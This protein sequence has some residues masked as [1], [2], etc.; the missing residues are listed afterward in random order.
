MI[1]RKLLHFAVIV[2]MLVGMVGFVLPTPAAAAGLLISP[3]SVTFSPQQINTQGGLPPAQ[4]GQYVIVNN[5]YSTPITINDV[6][7]DTAFGNATSFAVSGNGCLANGV[8]YQ[9]Q[10]GDNCQFG[11]VFNPK[12]LGDLNSR[13]I[14]NSTDLN[15][16][17]LPASYVS[18][19]GTGTSPSLE[20]APTALNFTA[21]EVNTGQSPDQGVV[22]RNTGQGA[23][24]VYNPTLNGGAPSNFV[25]T[26]NTCGGTIGPSLTCEIRVAFF[27]QS[28]GTKTETLQIVTSAN[29]TT[30]Q[31]AQ[32]LLT[33]AAMQGTI[34]ANP[35]SINF[36]DRLIN[37]IS[38]TTTV[39]LTNN[40]G[41]TQTIPAMSIIND[42]GSNFFL[43]ADNCT[44]QTLA[45]NGG[46][47]TFG[48]F[49]RPTAAG[50]QAA[51]VQISRTPGNGPGVTPLLVPMNGNGLAGGGNVTIAPPTKDFGSTPLGQQGSA[52]AFVVTNNGPSTLSV[53]AV[54]INGPNAG[55]FSIIFFGCNNG[56]V[57][58]PTGGNCTVVVEYSPTTP[59]IGARVAS[60]NV[61]LSEGATPGPTVAS[62]AAALNATATA[63]LQQTATLTPNPQDFGSVQIGAQST[64]VVFTMTNTGSQPIGPLGAPVSVGAN[65]DQFVIVSASD[66]FNKTLTTASPTCTFSAFFKPTATG[67]L[68]AS[69]SVPFQG[70][71]TTPAVS[72]TVFG[73]GTSASATLTPDPKDFGTVAVGYSSG[74][75]TFTLTNTSNG[76]LL[77]GAVA[78]GG[79]PEFTL[80]K[81]DCTGTTLNA[82]APGNTCEIIVRFTPTGGPVNSPKSGSLS[83]ALPNAGVATA[84]LSG[85]PIAP[86]AQVT[87]TPQ[88]A[89]FGSVAIGYSSPIQTFTL[90]NTGTTAVT[91][92]APA[93]AIAPANPDFT[94]IASGCDGITLNPA[95]QP[96]NSCTILVRFNPQAG[97]IGNRSASLA[98]NLGPNN[99]FA[100][101]ALNGQ[102]TASPQRS[103]TLTPATHDFGNVV[104]GQLG[105]I[106]DFVLTNT[107]TTLDL[108]ITA[109]AILNSDNTNFTI[110]SDGCAIPTLRTL[111]PGQ[112]CTIQV[113]F[114]PT[115]TGLKSTTLTVALPNGGAVNASLFGTSITNTYTVTPTQLAFGDQAS[116]T[117]S[118]PKFVTVTNTSNGTLDIGGIVGPAANFTIV[119]DLCSNKTLAIGGS[120]TFGVVF[121]PT[122][123]ATGP[124][125]NTVS[126]PVPAGTT[127]PATVNLTGNVTAA[128]QGAVTLDP[129]AFNF[130]NSQVPT[131]TLPHTFTLTNNG[132]KAVTV[133]SVTL[134]GTSPENFSVIL[135]NNCTGAVLNPGASCSVQVVFRPTAVGALQATLSFVTDAPGSP[136]VAALY[137]VG[138][139][140][141]VTVTS[142]TN[143]R[144]DFGNV[145]IG[146]QSMTQRV[147]VTNSS[148]GP[149]TFAA[150]AKDGNYFIVNDN[151]ASKTLEAG[152]TCTFDVLFAP[153]GTPGPQPGSVTIN[154]TAVGGAPAGTYVVALYGI[155][156]TSQVTITPNGGRLT[157]AD[158]QVGTQSVAQ[159]LTLTNGSGGPITIGTLG[160]AGQYLAFNDRCTG[161]TIP[162]SGTCTLG[163]I[164]APTAVGPQNGTVTIPVGTSSYVVA[165]YGVGITAVAT[166]DQS[167]LDFGNVLVGAESAPKTVTVTNRSAGPLSLG[168]V[169]S[170][171]ARYVVSVD[172][173]S[174]TTIG[175]GASCTFTVVFRPD[176]TGGIVNAQINVNP[177]TA[178]NATTLPSPLIITVKGVGITAAAT[179]SPV[180]LDFGNQ[181]TNTPSGTQTI[182]FTNNNVGPVSLTGLSIGGT[183]LTPTTSAP[184]DFQIVGNFCAPRN[185][186]QVVLPANGSCTVS[187]FF[188][189]TATGQ[190]TALLQITTNSNGSPFTAL[191][192]GVGTTSSVAITPGS[193]DFVQQQVGVQTAPQTITLVNP[194]NGPLT[195]TGMTLAG[196]NPGE[197]ILSNDT[198]TNAVLGNGAG[199][200]VSCTVD[201]SF[202]PTSQGPKSGV[203]RFTTSAPGGQLDVTLLGTGFLPV[204]VL[205]AAA[206]DF[207]NQVISITSV[208]Q[209]VTVTNRGPGTLQIDSVTITGANAGD[210]KILFNNG[211][212]G[213]MTPNQSCQVQVNFTPTALGQRQAFLTFNTNQTLLTGNGT[214]V[215]TYT[216]TVNVAGNVAGSGCTTSISPVGPYL[217]NQQVTL[218]ATFNPLTTVFNGWTLDGTFVGFA[219]PLNFSVDNSS[220]N[221]LA[222]CVPKP[223]FND[224]NPGTPYNDAIIQMTARGF[225]RVYGDGTFGPNDGIL[226]AQ[227]AAITT[228]LAGW[229]NL[230][231][232]NI[233][234]DRCIASG[235]VDDELWNSV[236]VT[237]FFQ[238]AR[239]YDDSTY[240]PFD[241][242]A[243]IQAVAFITRTMVKL[244][245]WQFQPDN[246]QIYP[247]IDA[248]TGHRIDISTYYFY[249]GAV[250]GTNPVNNWNEWDQNSTRAYFAGIYW[251]AYQSYFGVDRM[252]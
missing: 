195:I 35:G 149:I 79:T 179:F 41:Q 54:F 217:G 122:G 13:V 186:A 144:L 196:T 70:T 238:V 45:P 84:Q 24:V 200:R 208:A 166:L 43:V 42:G 178:P 78:L 148:N 209:T 249:V 64:P 188:Q 93:A 189:P 51:Q 199:G 87:L 170:P 31:N 182:T 65:A 229:S 141:R 194:S 128:P 250:P 146:T 37:T 221:V 161:Q 108:P 61:G 207:G 235:C 19:S 244:G 154:T 53:N 111:A 159:T 8:S 91:L 104:S 62:V 83:V 100:I 127:A 145:Q 81:N 15:G 124:V 80:V 197:F 220:H 99:G 44:T 251:Q 134:A 242:V 82:A 143:G 230:V 107:S 14:I 142:P 152:A 150:P 241:Q 98:V 214:P 158:T 212:A 185:G 240:R 187:F 245:Y 160:I 125:V 25:I 10:P 110:L 58:N 205:Q 17:A 172:N 33:G 204:P 126:I 130:G 121:A 167:Q 47:C 135:G 177:A 72:A 137:G 32:V 131:P 225:I 243:N 115:T 190:R 109:A 21:Q 92:G 39:T 157:F 206:V 156:I 228:R 20:I 3:P 155:G 69:V 50:Q 119:G 210:F 48:V 215:P 6:F 71:T 153:T 105:P 224:V 133:T 227:M 55:D 1:W 96:G 94:L 163:V 171:D 97:V 193:L 191:L 175:A 95:R 201:V 28:V 120:C 101:A 140:P 46:T 38:P 12:A 239:G 181:P 139:S 162:A 147:T 63:A 73:T 213:Q 169:T 89:N 57:L 26:K 7:V 76:P 173:C 30:P 247:N 5:T 103:A 106:Q 22:I 74:P 129:A 18:V 136:T 114:N 56:T 29:N 66:C 60:L 183:P 236:A 77:V 174:N 192:A 112:I 75:Q 132:T 52:Q 4:G 102:A 118:A 222:T 180:K 49:F 123:I 68:S 246:T 16:A 59:P 216:I 138:I 9:I 2:S 226:R 223:G 85:T 234:T 203:A 211:C 184:N 113:R 88:A 11:I 34:S 116:G 164:F 165:L 219:N 90:T 202:K 67:L 36:P 231:K 252:P 86:T 176:Q 198:C 218:T 27:P 237:A 232:P 168:A 117:A 233:F 151:C 248:G 40:S 23:L